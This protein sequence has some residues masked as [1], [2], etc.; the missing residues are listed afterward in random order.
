[1]TQAPGEKPTDIPMPRELV[2]AIYSY[3]SAHPHREVRHMVSA[4][5]V[6]VSSANKPGVVNFPDKER[7]DG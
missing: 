5:E 3:L 7:A 4:I 2:D 6:A 1:M